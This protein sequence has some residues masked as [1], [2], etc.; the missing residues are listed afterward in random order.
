MKNTTY[1][2]N[3]T[4]TTPSPIQVITIYGIIFILSSIGN[5]LLCVVTYK[6]H[7]RRYSSARLFI[8]NLA[9]ADLIT[10][11]SIP[12]IA[13]VTVFD[14]F[15]FDD[16]LCKT[17]YSVRNWA[18]YATALNLVAISYDR[19]LC[20]RSPLTFGLS[21]RSTI[22]LI[23]IV[24]F[25]ALI[26][27]FPQ[28]VILQ[29]QEFHGD[30]YCIEAWTSLK[31][32]QAYSI[33]MAVLF[34]FIPL[35]CI[36]IFNTGIALTI[37]KAARQEINRSKVISKSKRKITIMMA[38]IC[39]IFFSC[40]ALAYILII[41]IDFSALPLNPFN[42]SDISIFLIADY[43]AYSHSIWNPIIY[44]LFT[45]AVR[46]YS[47]KLLLCTRSKSRN[48]VIEKNE[49]KLATMT[50]NRNLS[51]SNLTMVQPLQT[52]V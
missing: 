30:H 17:I 19:L 43:I 28:W 5:V 37:Y 13:V 47:N 52:T 6:Q 10:T 38:V 24:W 41:L 15:P 20:I 2:N 11:V 51:K 35:L 8:F 39:I 7:H 50:Q 40:Y 36:C 3:S 32:R 14:E 49:T 18:V 44:G 45:I 31:S 34:Y 33:S 22:T 9:I 23:L 25:T 1:H 26:A 27:V 16:F 29:V 42:S 4:G 21:K 12:F 46:K 48:S